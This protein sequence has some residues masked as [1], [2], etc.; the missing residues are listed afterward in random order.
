MKNKNLTILILSGLLISM[1]SFNSCKHDDDDEVTGIDKE[2]CD[3]AKNSS[4]YTWYKKTDSLL[5]KSAGS[6]HSQPYL[7]TR[8]NSTA[9]TMLDSTGK[10]IAGTDF[11]EGSMVVKELYTDMSTLDLYAILYKKQGH[12]YADANGWVWGY[13][14]ADGSVRLSATEKGTSC[15]SCHSQDGNIDYMLMNKYF[16]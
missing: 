9:T 5:I 14:N 1:W 10:V 3:M 4:G 15:I 7:R 8:Y 16:P 2:L 6:G 11:P 13:I 12:E